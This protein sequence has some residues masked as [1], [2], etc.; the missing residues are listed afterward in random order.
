[1]R[2]SGNIFERLLIKIIPLCLTFGIIFLLTTDKS[3][4]K[5]FLPF[6]ATVAIIWL[7]DSLTILSKKIKRLTIID[8]QLMLGND[9]ISIEDVLT[10][11]PRKDKRRG[12][13]IKTIEIEYLKDDLSKRERIITKPAF[14]DLFGN[15]FKTIDLLVSRF[16]QLKERILEETED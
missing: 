10:I 16:P 13:D 15:K 4:E 3:I 11:V 6:T 9:K 1:M 8:N 12:I 2:V 14:L 7:F 5:L